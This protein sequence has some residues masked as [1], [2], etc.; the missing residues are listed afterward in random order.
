MDFPGKEFLCESGFACA[1]TSGNDVDCRLACRHERRVFVS[2][3]RGNLENQQGGSQRPE[4]TFIR[5]SPAV[6]DRLLQGLR[7]A[8]GAAVEMRKQACVG[9]YLQLL[10]DFVADVASGGMPGGVWNARRRSFVCL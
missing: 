5:V 9:Q 7:N 6:R 8:P 4:V 1:V 2:P 3:V 10:A